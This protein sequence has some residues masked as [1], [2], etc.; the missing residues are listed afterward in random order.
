MCAISLIRLAFLEPRIPRLAS[1]A[2]FCGAVKAHLSRA[3]PCQ[4]IP[5]RAGPPRQTAAL[6]LRQS[7]RPAR[8]DM[9]AA[10][11]MELGA[12]HIARLLGAKEIDGLGHLLGLAEAA[13]R[14]LLLDDLLGAGRKDGGIDFAW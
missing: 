13:E 10:V 11:D 1:R 9:L 12:I 8:S 6:A 4:V 14:N 5:W 3:E 2:G 7:D